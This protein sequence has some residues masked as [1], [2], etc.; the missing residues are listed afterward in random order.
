M[1]FKRTAIPWFELANTA[2]ASRT[3]TFYAV[4]AGNARDTSLVTLYD[5]RTG[6]GTLSN[7]H[8]LDASGKF[9]QPV[10]V[11]EKTIAVLS[12]ADGTT[13]ETGIFEPN[14]SDADVTAAAASASAAAASA[15]SAQSS[16]D[17]A[18]TAQTA[19]EAAQAAAEAAQ[20]AAEAAALPN[21]SGNANKFV[22]SDG[23]TASWVQRTLTSADASVT[24]NPTTGDLGVGNVDLSVATFDP[25]TDEGILAMRGKA[26]SVH[27]ATTSIN[28]TANR[29]YEIGAG[30]TGEAILA[31]LTQGQYIDIYFTATTG[32][33]ATIG[34][35]GNTSID[36]VTTSDT[37]TM[38]GENSRIG[39]R[40]YCPTTDNVV[41][42]IGIGVLAQ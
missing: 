42:M 26:T 13:H 30:G 21:Q 34:I 4:T 14:L 11:D 12:L 18:E 25:D 33:V 35:G 20:A 19:A 27:T 41:K 7:P 29:A 10:Y 24:F 6:S 1:A 36:G 38:D 8:T 39:V 16:E 37:I 15:T 9:A 2:Y 28:L 5:A 23:T 32:D 22:V 17:D 40:Y 3:V 31:T